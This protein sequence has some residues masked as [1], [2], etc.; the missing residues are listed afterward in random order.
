MGKNDLEW[1]KIYLEWVSCFNFLTSTVFFGWNGTQSTIMG[2][3][4]TFW[5]APGGGWC[6]WKTNF[7]CLVPSIE[8]KCRRIGE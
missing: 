8:K 1:T 7:H 3:R 5:G 2:E 4:K 6:V